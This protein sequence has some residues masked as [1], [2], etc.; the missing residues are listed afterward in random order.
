MATRRNKTIRDMVLSMGVIVAAVLVFVFV[1][2]GASFSPGGPSGGSGPVPTADLVLG[3]AAAPQH[4]QFAV[5]TPHGVPATW[6]ANSFSTTPPGGDNAPPAA[7]RAGWI[8]PGGAFITVIQSAGTPEVVETTE[9]GTEHTVGPAT[10]SIEAGGDTWTVVPG[11]RAEMAWVRAAA[12]I[13]VIITGS[14]SAAD[15]ATLATTLH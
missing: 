7:V 9:L 13:T 2:G 12:G 8:V 14:A 1:Q 5:V 10:G 4:V 11:R 6:K 3:F 15:F